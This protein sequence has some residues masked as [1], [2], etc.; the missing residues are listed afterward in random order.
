MLEEFLMKQCILGELSKC[1]LRVQRN[2]C[3][4]PEITGEWEK[5]SP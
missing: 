2:I 5:A 3:D 1:S 4:R